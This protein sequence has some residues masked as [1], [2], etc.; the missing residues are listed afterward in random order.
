MIHYF[1][2]GSNMDLDFL[3]KLGVRV[4][5]AEK[6]ILEGWK[7]VFNVIDDEIPGAGFANIIPDPI[8]QV[9]GVIYTIDEPSVEALDRYEDYPRDYDKITLAIQTEDHQSRS[10]L[11]YIGQPDRLSQNL[12][13]T[14][15]TRQALLNGQRF[16]SPAYY[17][18]LL[19]L[20]TY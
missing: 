15:A 18:E 13:P 16:L 20:K 2:Y 1:A 10:C 19:R 4:Y 9:E 14:C 6:G 11:L 7:L 8:A 17:Q 12:T 3:Q 5:H